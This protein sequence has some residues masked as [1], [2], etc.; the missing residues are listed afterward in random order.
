MRLSWR[1]VTWS[2]VKWRAVPYRDVRW[3]EVP[4]PAE[5]VTDCHCHCDQTQ[6]L[7][8]C[9]LLVIAFSYCTQIKK[10]SRIKN[11][12]DFVQIIAASLRHN[13]FESLSS[14]LQL[15]WVCYPPPPPFHKTKH[16]STWPTTPSA[17]GDTL[18]R[19][20]EFI[21]IPRSF[22]FCLFFSVDILLL[23]HPFGNTQATQQQQQQLQ[24]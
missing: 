3:G 15:K 10:W 8:A 1:D 18:I 17:T 4:W 6:S 13:W 11:R 2:E 14:S 23:V 21:N 24:Q 20:F 9:L 5:V 19:G 22:F 12:S 16:T 7:S